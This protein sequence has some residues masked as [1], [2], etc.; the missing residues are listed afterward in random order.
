[1]LLGGYLVFSWSASVASTE[2]R[3]ADP[4]RESSEAD[5]VLAAAEEQAQPAA[6]EAPATVAPSQSTPEPT[7]TPPAEARR[8]LAGLPRE[9]ATLPILM[10]HH[11]NDLPRTVTDAQ[12]RDLTVPTRSFKHHLE[13]LESTGVQ[14]VSLDELIEH[15]EGGPPLPERAVILSFDDG[16]E[17]NYRL[18]YPL[19]RQYRMTATFFVVAN[20]VG[21]PGYMTWEQLREMQRHGMS[22]ESH[23]LDHLDL[24]IQPR[25]ELQRQLFE[26]RRKLDLNLPRPVRFLAY[27]SGAYNPLVISA[28]KLA[29]YR[30]AVSINHGHVQ[31]RTGIYELNRVRVKGAE[32]IDSLVAKVAPP[33]WKDARGTFGR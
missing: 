32:T 17:D 19:L 29:G 11:V 5:P 15:L 7:P 27:P 9:T 30:A 3:P 12:L 23:S 2:Q 18:A 16:Y 28:T 4:L 8:P 10:Y 21:Q 25:A 31:R 1:L 6:Q 26:S 13:F 20:L 33:P 24:S 22:I 14:T